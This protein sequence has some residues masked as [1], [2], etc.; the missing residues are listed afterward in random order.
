MGLLKN[1]IKYYVQNTLIKLNLYEPKEVWYSY[2]QRD[3][4]IVDYQ[5][6]QIPGLPYTFRGPK[7]DLNS[8]DYV[9]FI[10]AAQTFGCLCEHPFPDL[11]Q[12]KFDVDILNLGMGGAGPEHFDDPKLLDLINNAKA[13]VVQVMSARSV[14]NSYMKDCTGIITIRET[15]E[16][17]SSK[18]A[19]RRVL[20][21]SEDFARKI[22]EETRRNYVGTYRN[23]L[24]KI[25]VPAIL[26]WF[27]V[28]E[29]HYIDDFS[30]VKSL[31]NSFPQMVN[32]AMLH[33][34]ATECDDIVNC[35]TNRGIPQKL[36]SRFNG[37][38]TSIIDAPGNKPKTH[39]YYYPTPEMHEDAAKSLEH[40]VAK[41]LESDDN[42]LIDYNS[43][44]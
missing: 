2:S 37:K 4:E 17:V 38:R 10:G 22:V 5:A 43:R 12:Q 11:I 23:L 7:P 33:E 35:T 13:V 20:D 19:Y 41:I 26:L 3:Y 18:E 27:S 36:I 8:G 21:Q 44:S 6:Y 1:R 28:R 14:E 29:P 24:N 40:V 34:I 25:T 32:Q 42:T 9:A 15:G 30:S 31:F 39:N 16:K